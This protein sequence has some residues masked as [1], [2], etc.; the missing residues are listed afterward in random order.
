MFSRVN[1]FNNLPAGIG[2]ILNVGHLYYTEKKLKD[3]NYINKMISMLKNK[4]YEMHL[5]DND[6]TEDHHMLI[7]KGNIP[8]K[9]ILKDVSQNKEMPHL[10]I[11]A[12]KMRHKYS[13]NDLKD[14]IIELKRI[15]ENI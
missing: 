10:I 6:G 5:N 12:H 8:I 3:N 11:E 9:D 1:D 2:I 13:D 15:S 7:G 4:I 14:N